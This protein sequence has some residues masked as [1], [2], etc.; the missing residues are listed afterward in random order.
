MVR[1]RTD[2]FETNVSPSRRNNLK[3]LSSPS[4]NTHLPSINKQFSNTFPSFCHNGQKKTSNKR[5]LKE[6]TQHT[7]EQIIEWYT[8]NDHRVYLNNPKVYIDMMGL[9]QTQRIWGN[10]KNKTCQVLCDTIPQARTKWTYVR[11][12]G[13]YMKARQTMRTQKSNLIH[14][15]FPCMLLGPK[16]HLHT[17]S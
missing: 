5:Q 14:I 10:G 4:V 3:Q 15:R 6:V 1:T 8:E 11:R 2:M 9:Q 13:N 16:G 17:Y 7:H 12:R